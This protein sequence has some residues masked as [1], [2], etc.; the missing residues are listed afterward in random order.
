MK[1]LVFGAAGTIVAAMQRHGVHRL[2]VTSMLGAG[3]SK[4]NAPLL[5]HLLRATFLR[6]A[7]TFQR[8]TSAPGRG[9]CKR[10]RTLRS[11]PI[12]PC[13][14]RIGV[15]SASRQASTSRRDI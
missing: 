4:A 5:L 15:T 13:G 7:D 2:V 14:F 10:L 12:H 1:I 3:D 8:R 11:I 6:G 9:D